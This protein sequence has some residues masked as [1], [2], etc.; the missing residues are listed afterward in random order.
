MNTRTMI[1][2]LFIVNLMLVAVGC[3][4]YIVTG[5]SAMVSVIGLISI[6]LTPGLLMANSELE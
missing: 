6:V 4:H 3:L 2:I 5:K 1:L